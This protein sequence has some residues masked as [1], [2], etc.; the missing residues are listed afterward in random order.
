MEEEFVKFTC[1]DYGKDQA[2][3]FQIE[4]MATVQVRCRC[5]RLMIKNDFK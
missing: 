4:A 3:H 2:K 5:G 1:P